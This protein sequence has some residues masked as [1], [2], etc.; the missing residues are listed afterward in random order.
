[1]PSVVAYDGPGVDAL[2]RMAI[3]EEVDL[4]EFEITQ[5]SNDVSVA[6]DFNQIGIPTNSRIRTIT[7][8]FIRPV[9]MRRIEVLS[10]PK[11]LVPINKLTLDLVF[12]K[13]V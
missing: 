9:R 4:G 6:I 11:L 2:E 5:S 12:E 7:F 10:Q 3:I 13:E 8:D 1:M